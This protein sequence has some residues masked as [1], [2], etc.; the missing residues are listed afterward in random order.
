MPRFHSFWPQ[1]DHKLCFMSHGLYR[2]KYRPS[3]V[4]MWQRVKKVLTA[5]PVGA[6]LGSLWKVRIPP[7]RTVQDW[8]QFFLSS[9]NTDNRQSSLHPPPAGLF[10]LR[11]DNPISPDLF[12]VVSHFG[13]V[14]DACF[15]Q[16]VALLSVQ[17]LE[18]F[19]GWKA[20]RLH[21]TSSGHQS[22]YHQKS[23]KP[24][25]NLHFYENLKFCINKNVFFLS[26]IVFIVTFTAFL[27]FLCI[28]W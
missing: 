1:F 9:R 22:S 11:E 24:F 5:F 18:P 13:L 21:E 8:L 4:D 6:D 27:V 20:L 12:A 23:Q 2:R 14:E 3:S 15:L 7:W 25:L 19:W 16:Q 28:C 10:P 17:S 26:C